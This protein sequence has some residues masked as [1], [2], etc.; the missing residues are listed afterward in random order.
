MCFYYLIFKHIYDSDDTISQCD[1]SNNILGK[2]GYVWK[3]QKL[4]TSM[5]TEERYL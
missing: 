2:V 4:Q 3:L 5:Q 1:V